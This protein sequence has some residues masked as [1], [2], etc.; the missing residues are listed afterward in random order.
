MGVKSYITLGP[1][2]VVVLY[3]PQHSAR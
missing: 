1:I 2:M 3:V